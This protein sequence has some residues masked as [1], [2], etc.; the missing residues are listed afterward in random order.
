[1]DDPPKA[2]DGVAY[3]SRFIDDF[4]RFPETNRQQ[5]RR[6]RIERSGMTGLA[7]IEQALDSRNRAGGAQAQWF[8]EQQNAMKIDGHRY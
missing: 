2:S 4:G 5:S 7:R 6:K 8:I 3:G 1:M